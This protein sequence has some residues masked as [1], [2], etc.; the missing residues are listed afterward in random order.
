VPTTTFPD[1]LAHAFAAG[2]PL[3]YAD[4]A[5]EER[6][7]DYTESMVRARTAQLLTWKC[8]DG[9][10]LVI[11]G[12]APR[13]LI[14]R[15]E[16]ANFQALLE[17]LIRLTNEGKELRAPSLVIAFD[18]VGES[19]TEGSSA[20]LVLNRLMKD[21]HIKWEP[22]SA[23]MPRRT[24]MLTGAGWS[25]PTALCGYLQTLALPLPTLAETTE[26]F[27]NPDQ[28]FEVPGDPKDLAR[29]AVG[30][31]HLTIENLVRRCAAIPTRHAKDERV[32][33]AEEVI[34]VVKR[35]EIRR[36]G[37]LE[38]VKVPDNLQLGGFENFQRWFRGRQAFLLRPGRAE[39]SPRGVLFLGF[40]GCGKSHAARW[41]ARE[42]RLPL[43]AMDLGRIQDRWVGSSEARMRTAL[44][45]I[46]AVAPVVLFIDEIEKGLAGA[47]TES[48]GVTTRLVGQLLTW[49]SDHRLPVFVVA[50]CNSVAVPPELMRAGRIDAR[51]LVQLPS[52]EERQAIAKAAAAEI[53]LAPLDPST[54]AALVGMSD[55]FSGAEI[56]QLLVE[57]AY[58]AGHGNCQIGTAHL[59]GALAFVTPLSQTAK[60]QELKQQYQ[61]SQGFLLA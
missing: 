17:G 2:T 11:P 32:R 59:T 4:T 52:A 60:G 19:P 44:R 61:S 24:L 34:D 27:A 37:I 18:A 42:L 56:R 30:L 15:A 7:Y 1:E 10:H 31:P 21:L 5:E 23:D 53:G 25:V 20:S 29:R 38:I 46:E 40:P 45:T 58:S 49:L 55:G 12:G 54:L 26:Y 3:I 9:L 48:T 47:G 33:Q 43:V 28:G 57:A 51:F 16:A 39:L 22:V 41:I 35:E 6:L 50:T 36:T 8:T 14:S 13:L